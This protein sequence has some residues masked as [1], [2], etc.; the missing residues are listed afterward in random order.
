[1][2]IKK[3]HLI[4]VDRRYSDTGCNRDRAG[5]GPARKGPVRVADFILQELPRDAGQETGQQ[6]RH[7]LA[8]VARLWRFLRPVPRRQPAGHRRD[9]CAHRH[10]G[11]ALGHPGR[12]PA[13]PSQRPAGACVRCT[14][15]GPERE[16]KKRLTKNTVRGRRQRHHGR[17]RAG[18]GKCASRHSRNRPRRSRPPGW[19]PVILSPWSITSSATTRMRSGRTPGQLGRRHPGGD[20]HWKM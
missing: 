19:R 20:D 11:A 5:N 18:G 6:R 2:H 3:L 1:M 7:G 12:L 9:C 17:G 4:L 15:S 10:G 8:P 13:V 14:P 16:K